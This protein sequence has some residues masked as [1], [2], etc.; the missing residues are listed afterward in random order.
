MYHV[1]ALVIARSVAILLIRTAQPPFPGCL[2]VKSMRLASILLTID[3]IAD[4]PE[5]GGAGEQMERI[6]AVRGLVTR[7]MLWLRR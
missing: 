2:T 1:R 5:A 6:D 3:F 4:G 7:S